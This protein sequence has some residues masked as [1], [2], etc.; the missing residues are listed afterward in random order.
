MHQPGQVGDVRD[1]PAAGRNAVRVA[2]QVEVV[3][4]A[5]LDDPGVAG[6][7]GALAEQPTGDRQNARIGGGFREHRVFVQ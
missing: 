1:V 5:R 7:D 4:G 3:R 6:E 2:V